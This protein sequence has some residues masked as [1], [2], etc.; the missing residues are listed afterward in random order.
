MKDA[1]NSSGKKGKV[2]LSSNTQILFFGERI[3]LKAHNVHTVYGIS[4]DIFYDKFYSLTYDSMYLRPTDL[5]TC[6]V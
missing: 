1:H 4:S 6:M 2:N 3:W 5:L